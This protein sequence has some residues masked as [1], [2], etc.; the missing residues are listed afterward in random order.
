[1]DCYNACNFIIHEKS[2]FLINILY[3]VFITEVSKF[4]F[5]NVFPSP[6]ILLMTLIFRR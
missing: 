2:D 6:V 1:P 3:K 5:I 4:L